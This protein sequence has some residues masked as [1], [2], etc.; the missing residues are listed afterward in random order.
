MKQNGLCY[1]CFEK[2]T[3]LTTVPWIILETNAVVNIVVVYV[4]KN[5][6]SETKADENSDKKNDL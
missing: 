1:I 5:L 4:Y 2:G 6:K 3:F